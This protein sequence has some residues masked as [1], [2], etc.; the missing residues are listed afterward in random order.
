MATVSGSYELSVQAK[1]MAP[2]LL[3]GR[4][5]EHMQ[6]GDTLLTGMICLPVVA[7]TAS[8]VLGVASSACRVDA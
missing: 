5:C 7:A 1:E 8:T 2:D 3:S 6:G 4:L